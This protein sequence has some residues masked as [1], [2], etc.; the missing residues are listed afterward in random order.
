MSI[1]HT[2]TISPNNIQSINGTA[3]INGIYMA[4]DYHPWSERTIELIVKDLGIIPDNGPQAQRTNDYK[5]HTTICYMDFKK[6]RTS[7]KEKEKLLKFTNINGSDVFN[8]IKPRRP[9][10]QVPVKII[11]L[12]TFN[13]PNGKNLHIRVQSKF[14]TSEFNRSKNFGI[15]YGFRNYVPHITLKNDLPNDYV[16]PKEIEK[17][18]IGTVLYSNDEYIEAME[19]K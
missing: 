3:N 1:K 6:N 7:Q 17:K 13:T 5:Y 4:I 19:L 14:L 18:Y 11:G 16:I 8:E 12:G 10:I 9:K 2:G 15:K